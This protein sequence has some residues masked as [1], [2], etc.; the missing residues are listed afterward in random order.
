MSPID[1]CGDVDSQPPR[2]G[3]IRTVGYFFVHS[4]DPMIRRLYGTTREANVRLEVESDGFD[5]IAVWVS[6]PSTGR[7]EAVPA[8]GAAPWLLYLLDMVFE[9][10]ESPDEPWRQ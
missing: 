1:R 5:P 6:S 4:E 3:E 9:V 2:T 8:E 7:R 10:G